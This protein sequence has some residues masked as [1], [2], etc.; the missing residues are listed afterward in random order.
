[1]FKMKAN[2]LDT[3]R[4]SLIV[5]FAVI[6]IALDSLVTPGFSAGIWYGW[7]FIMSPISGIILGPRDGFIATLISVM[8]GHTIVFRESIFEF[9]FTLGAPIGS[10]VTGLIFRGEKSKILVYY[11]ILVA[12]YFLTPVAR[13]LPIWGM[14]DVYIAYFVLVV[15]FFFER[16]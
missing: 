7:V 14:W 8:V 9:I 12:A 2:S 4:I 13:Q 15:L 10:A 1:M 16:R 6:S 3:R 5:V 11:T